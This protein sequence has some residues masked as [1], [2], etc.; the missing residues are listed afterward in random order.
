MATQHPETTLQAAFSNPGATPVPWDEAR[1]QLAQAEIYW[2][3]TVRPDGRPHVTPLMA[4]WFNGAL[5]FCV[6]TNERKTRNLEGNTA[7]AITTGCNALYAGRDLVIEGEAAQ[8]EDE[9]TLQQIADAYEA[10][11]GSAWHFDVQ[12]G[13][14]RRPEDGNIALVFAIT[15]QTAFGFSKGTPFSQTRWRF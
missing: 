9:A 12:D 3:T 1:E 15:P 6:G 7:C 5:H 13:A 11:Y 4:V 10:K 2:L 8:I 14:W